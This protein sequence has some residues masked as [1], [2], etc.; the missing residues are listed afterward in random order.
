MRW[1]RTHN[2]RVSRCHPPCQRTA[3]GHSLRELL[4]VSVGLG[5]G[6]RERWGCRSRQSLRSR[7]TVT[8]HTV[9]NMLGVDSGT[10]G[11]R[12]PGGLLAEQWHCLIDISGKIMMETIKIV[13]ELGLPLAG[14]HLHVTKGSILGWLGSGAP[15][16]HSE[17]TN[18]PKTIKQKRYGNE[19]N[20]DLK[21]GQKIFKKLHWN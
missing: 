9:N 13:L 3:L 6:C 15:E 8:T 19:L 18:K 2:C 11:S 7:R 1:E 5:Q 20:K 17:K 4:P 14:L 10:L 21:N 12:S 16:A